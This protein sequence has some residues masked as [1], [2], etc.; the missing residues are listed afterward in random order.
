MEGRDDAAA[1]AAAAAARSSP[2]SGGGVGG[3][4]WFAY[5]VLG[6]EGVAGMGIGR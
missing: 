5:N 2:G 4:G 3:R 6:C 1:A